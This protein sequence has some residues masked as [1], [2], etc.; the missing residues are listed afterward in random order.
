ML[1]HLRR[2]TRLKAHQERCILTKCDSLF[3]FFPSFFN[4]L[5]PQ[6]HTYMHTQTH[7]PCLTG[8]LLLMYPILSPFFLSSL[9]SASCFFFAEI[10]LI[11]NHSLLRPLCSIFFTLSLFVIS[12]NTIWKTVQ[13]L[14][15]LTLS[16]WQKS[17]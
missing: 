3:N 1:L 16:P 7:T 9:F 15:L 10:S 14:R 13:N 6:I 12:H 17:F 2:E 8:S 11:T 4:L 5:T